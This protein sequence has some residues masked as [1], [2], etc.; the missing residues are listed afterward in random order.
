[1]DLK[2]KIILIAGPTASGKS[3][4]AI[5][6]AKKINGE[7]I[8]A[9]SMQVY[10]EFK[11]LTARPIKK[12]EKEVKHHL[13]GF[14]SVKK[15]FSTG[16]WLKHC[17]STI[18]KLR[19]KRKTPIIVGG[20]GLY[21]KALIDGLVKIPKIPI[22]LR[23]LIIKDQRELGQKIFYKKLV[24]LDGLAKKNISSKDVQRSIRA[25]EVKKYTKIS[26]FKWFKKTKKNF[27]DK[28]FYKIYV[29]IPKDILSERIKKRIEK[30][31]K[32]G[33]FDE[34]DKFLKMKIKKNNNSNKI[35]GV[36]EIQDYLQSE[37][38]DINNLKEIL[39]IKTRQYAKRQKTWSNKF[40]HNWSKVDY[41]NFNFSKKS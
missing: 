18:K 15:N 33:A 25:F 22:R 30:M 34:V 5:N 29:D 14:C 20:T 12:D 40:M 10:K 28:D 38:K 31:L 17:I 24:K 4:I 2:S 39:L 8:N 7:I 37:N 23:N 27:E 36:R 13:Y 35:I 16:K 3:K 32:A 11:I 19:K 41:K 21:F 1:M 26:L 6:L 9:D